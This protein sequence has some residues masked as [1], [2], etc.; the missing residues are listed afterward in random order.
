M[1]PTSRATLDLAAAFDVR[2]WQTGAAGAPGMQLSGRV[3]LPEDRLGVGSTLVL[4]GAWWDVR[5][6]VNGVTLP[7]ATGGLAPVALEVGPHLRAGENVFA[8]SIMP[9]PAGTPPL[10]TGGGLASGGGWRT[11]RAD[12]QVAPRLELR[13]GAHVETVSLPLESGQVR[14]TATVQGAPE[15]S[16]VRFTVSLD[17]EQVADLGEAPVLAGVA[18]APAADWTLDDWRPGRPALYLAQAELR[19]P[20]GGILDRMARRTGALAVQGDGGGLHLGGDPLRL[21]AVRVTNQ[22]RDLPG[23]FRELVSGGA[24]SVE[25]HG[26]LLRS[27]WLDQADELGLPLVVVPRCVGRTNKGNPTPAI[28]A[29]QRAQDIRLVEHTAHHPSPV[30]WATEG[31][32]AASQKKRPGLPKVLWTEGL[33]T[34]PLDRPVSQHDVPARVQRIDGSR[35]GAPAQDSCLREGCRGAWITEVTWRGPAVPQMWSIMATRTE[36]ALTR[37][38]ALGVVI[39]TPRRSDMADWAPAWAAVAKAAAMP[40]PD[41]GPFRAS[42][43]VALRGG[44][45]GASVFVEAAGHPTVGTVLD[46]Q[47]AGTLRVWHEGAAL[48]RMGATALPIMV[49]SGSWQGWMETPRPVVVDLSAG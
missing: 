19:G 3:H 18:V 31:Q 42:G 22:E 38:Q 14:A 41:P 17:G 27:T 28:A 16:H 10:L 5:A 25:V 4:E 29:T 8:V 45:P 37:G 24:N 7:P 13:P 2:P 40:A 15:G 34:D 26:E 6:T 46:G 43:V 23:R 11:D 35:P 49:E 12:L 44:V 1:D 36:D 33:L 48:V 30:L 20:D 32:T 47:G 39:P 21:M 9:P